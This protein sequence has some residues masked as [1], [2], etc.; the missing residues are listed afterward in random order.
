MHVGNSK[1]WAVCNP[2][3]SSCWLGVPGAWPQLLP[4]CRHGLAAAQ[5]WRLLL[6]DSVFS[7]MLAVQSAHALL[8]R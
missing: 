2:S 7:D 8:N 3:R 4:G 1:W 6:H 5:D